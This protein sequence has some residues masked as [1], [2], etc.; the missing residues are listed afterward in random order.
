MST[1]Y[2][3]GEKTTDK[4]QW[5]CASRISVD[6]YANIQIPKHKIVLSTSLD[7]FM[8]GVNHI[9]SKILK[10]ELNWGTTVKC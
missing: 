10:N 3:A 9:Q 1:H 4:I 7:I 8:T 5:L 6:V 2:N